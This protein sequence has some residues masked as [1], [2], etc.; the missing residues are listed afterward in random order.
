M[1]LAVAIVTTSTV[2][3]QSVPHQNSGSST[4]KMHKRVV[5]PKGSGKF[6]AGPATSTT[7][8]YEHDSDKQLDIWVSRCNDAGGGMELGD[9]G[10]YRCVGTDGKDIDNW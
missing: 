10:N 6:S 1:V 8:K 4:L 9:D 5:P 3:A 7:H 2:N